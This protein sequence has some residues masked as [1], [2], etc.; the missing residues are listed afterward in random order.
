MRMRGVFYMFENGVITRS[1]APP[2]IRQTSQ[3]S[4]RVPTSGMLYALV[5]QSR[6]D[7]SRPLA[8]L[9]GGICGISQ[10]TPKEL[11]LTD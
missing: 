1:C 10:T 8:L 4:I 3:H 9:Y 2:T 6:Y 7:S 11:R 5:P